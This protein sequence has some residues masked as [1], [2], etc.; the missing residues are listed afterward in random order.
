VSKDLISNQKARDF[1][2][3]LDE[4]LSQ[5]DK[6][7]SLEACVA[8]YPTLAAQLEPLLRLA[9]RVK[10]LR[11]EQVP[12]PVTLQAARQRFLR[13]AAQLRSAQ[14][15]KARTSRVPWWVNL[16]AL[17]RKSMAAVVLATLLLVVAL[18]AGTIAASANSLPGDALYPVKRMTEEVQLLLT[19]DRQSKAQ[20]VQ[21][22]DE[23]RREE[24][25]AIASSQRIAEMSF[26]G[27]V[28]SV[29]GVHWTIGGVPVRT[30]AET[31]IEEDVAV[32]AFVRV[33]LRSLSN[34]TLLAMR[35]SV[36]P[37]S[38]SPEPTASPIPTTSPTTTPTATPTPTEVPATA[39]PIQPPAPTSTPSP[40]P[41][42]T[43]SATPSATATLIPPTPVPPREV[44]V[45]FEGRI[46][47]IAADVW[48]IDG[49]LV[50]IDANTR[51]DEQEGTAAVGA[52][53]RVIA[54]RQQDG[55]LLAIEITIE[56]AEQTPEQPFE[57]QGLIESFSPTQWIVGGHTLIITE[58]TLI[59]GT[60]HKGFLAEVKALRQSDGSLLAV[61][62]FVR[63]PTEEVQFE[64]VIQSLGAE[65]W[66]VDGV[67]VRLDAETIVEGTPAVGSR[68][69]V[70]GLLLPDG[71][72][73]ARRIMVQPLP[74]ATP[75]PM[76][77]PTQMPTTAPTTAQRAAPPGVG[78]RPA[79]RQVQL[80]L[81]APPVSSTE[82]PIVP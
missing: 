82:N 42:S 75:A 53:A 30:S 37:E 16:Q 41:T 78:Q 79:L 81:L 28:D 48:T 64:G 73:L 66:I 51:I 20:L 57:F 2:A 45:R 70:E 18:S 71:A 35:I 11:Q 59:E 76:L 52:M 40:T 15:D 32:G 61:H 72:V 24:A 29:D 22:L 31:V 55:T 67:T 7:E 34:G 47:A 6:G 26:R 13:E 63:P 27:R 21:K 62:I 54:I 23:R 49:Q 38:V 9:L 80:P 50:R 74:T 3:V 69:E 12:S 14:L 77:E 68:V 4:C 17:M 46:E 56:R 33:H 8:Q 5:I 39:A 58:D 44:K 10:A 60:P 25:K 19:F 36:E 43:P 65:E 1:E